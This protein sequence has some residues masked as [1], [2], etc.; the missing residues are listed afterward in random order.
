MGRHTIMNDIG[1]DPLACDQITHV[2]PGGTFSARLGNSDGGAEAE[3]LQYTVAV[4][5]NNSLFM[6]KYA[7]VLEDPGH[8][9]EEQPRFGIR[10]LDNSGQVVDSVCGQYT[11]VA[12]DSIS[13]FESCGN[14]RYKPWTTVGMDMTPYIGQNI[15]I[16]FSTGDCSKGAHFGYAYIDAFCSS[17]TINSSYCRGAQSTTLTAPPGFSYLWNTGE[18]TQNITVN[19][20][21]Q[22]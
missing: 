16:E 15:T 12:G 4:T 7:V 14:V 9:A 22:G 13:G 6:Y 3:R 10:I 8:I 19:N 17:L 2:A 18:T 11:V 21:V 5:A 20:P 1:T